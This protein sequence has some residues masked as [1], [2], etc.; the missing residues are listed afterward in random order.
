MQKKMKKMKKM[1]KR[2]TAPAP[3]G[4]GGD[5]GKRERESGVARVFEYLIKAFRDRSGD[6]GVAG[7]ST[8]RETADQEAPFAY[9]FLTRIA[10]AFRASQSDVAR[11]EAQK[12]RRDERRRIDTVDDRPAPRR[13]RERQVVGVMAREFEKTLGFSCIALFVALAMV[14]GYAVA[15]RDQTLTATAIGLGALFFLAVM[16][17]WL[18]AWRTRRG[19]FGS[20]EHEVRELLAFAK[21]YPTPE[22]FFDDNGHLLPAFDVALREARESALG[23]KPQ[24]ANP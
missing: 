21:R 19:Y 22:D 23:F 16:R 8:E 13:E 12:K 3:R 9:R 1:K 2:R 14:G 15:K 6:G 4:S 20:S 17:Q 18:L 7:F 11:A 5:A 24:A 10:D